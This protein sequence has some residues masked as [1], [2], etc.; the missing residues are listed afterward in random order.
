MTVS[1]ASV[2]FYWRVVD[3]FR[4]HPG[5]WRM[6]FAEWLVQAPLQAEGREL[7]LRLALQAE[8]SPSDDEF[9][10]VSRVGATGG[11]SLAF[12]RAAAKDLVGLSR[13]FAKRGYKLH[14]PIAYYPLHGW[15]A[16]RPADRGRERRFL[17]EL[18][19]RDPGDVASAVRSMDAFLSSMRGRSS[20]DWR[21]YLASWLWQRKVSV[22]GRPASATVMFQVAPADLEHKKLG[23]SSGITIWPAW[24]GRGR[25]PPWLANA[26]RPIER[27]FRTAGH[28]ADWVRLNG[29]Q[30]FLIT[31]H[32][33]LRGLP[34]LVRERRVLENLRLGDAQ[35]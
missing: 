6:N 25:M 23:I 18:A 15:K 27:Q 11:G 30:G 1:N 14:D 35:E 9:R 32:K 33:V 34:A 12:S 20:G 7:E 5:P 2:Q 4:A 28:R 8:I 21:P 3:H 10:V 13:V 31:S 29:G 24:S 26:K 19:E 17:A 16:P 22:G